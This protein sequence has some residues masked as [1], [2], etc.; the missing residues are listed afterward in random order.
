MDDGRITTTC[1]VDF[2]TG[3]LGR[4]R[5]GIPGE[6]RMLQTFQFNEVDYTMVYSSFHTNVT[7]YPI[8][9]QAYIDSNKD[10]VT[11]DLRDMGLDV[12]NTANASRIVINPVPTPAP[13][14]TSRPTSHPTARPTTSLKPSGIPS[15]RPSRRPTTA[16]LT[17]APSLFPTMSG[18]PSALP[19]EFTAVPS[20][21]PIEGN[22]AGDGV[23][24]NTV[25]VVS[26]VVAG[27]IILFGLLLY[28]RRRKSQREHEFQTNAAIGNRQDKKYP[29]A[30]SEGSWDAAVR[31]PA[32]YETASSPTPGGNVSGY[33]NDH[34]TNKIPPVVTSPG[35]MVSP[36]ESLASNQSLLSTG[37]SM[38]GDSGD[39][40][41]HTQNLA[42][43][44]DQY[45]DQNL[46]KMRADVEGNL[47]GFDGMMSQALTKAL[48]DDD[49][50]QVDPTE[51]LWGGKSKL[52][53]IEI[54]ASALGEVDNWLKR[55]ENASIEEK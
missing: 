42:D 38:A 22:N 6:G 27:S 32:G 46:E 5:L 13:T 26:V 24:N 10:M 29:G 19:T 12:T 25:I 8:F 31:K 11:L 53:G 15:D 7:A 47:N 30:A 43:E 36:S 52:T 21:S 48:I 28:Y 23:K 55:K 1:T 50:A 2:Q 33:G 17:S 14:T 41:D 49:E 51:L 18:A 3:L 16:P 45:K 34:Y 4:R 39:E 54:E 9:F 20:E 37:I 44:F 40:A 35:G